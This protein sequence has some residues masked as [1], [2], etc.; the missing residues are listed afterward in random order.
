MSG[1]TAGRLLRRELAPALL[2]DASLM[3]ILVNHVSRSYVE[4][5]RELESMIAMDL[6]LAA[7]APSVLLQGVLFH[8][9]IHQPV[10]SILVDA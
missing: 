7:T 10:Q 4:S 6:T 5:I 8:V 1:P 9:G 3:L 2:P